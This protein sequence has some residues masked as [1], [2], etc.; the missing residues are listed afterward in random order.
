M[1]P[2][3]L[4]IRCTSGG[5]PVDTNTTLGITGNTGYGLNYWST[6]HLHFELKSFSTFGTL[7]NDKGVGFGYTAAEP[8]QL[9]YFDPLVNM[10]NVTDLPSSK[11]VTTIA[12]ATTTLVGPGGAGATTYRNFATVK[13]GNYSALRISDPTAAPKCSLGWYQIVRLDAV[14]FPDGQ[15]SGKAPVTWICGDSVK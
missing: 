14:F 1:D 11:T 13:T 10:H 6:V 8:D 12:Q 15:T 3:L 2:Q 9:G 5:V 4:R 7:G